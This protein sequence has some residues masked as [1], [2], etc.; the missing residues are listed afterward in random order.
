LRKA[1][2]IGRPIGD[3][4]FLDR[5]EREAGRPLRRG[6]PGPRPKMSALSPQLK[7]V[8]PRQQYLSVHIRF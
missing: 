8:D 4:A 6:K 3:A 1:E 5:L 7:Y 2:T